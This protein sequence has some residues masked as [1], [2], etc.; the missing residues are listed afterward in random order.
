MAYIKSVD[1]FVGFLSMCAFVMAPS[2]WPEIVCVAIGY[3]VCNKLFPWKKNPDPGTRLIML[4][5]ELERERREKEMVKQENFLLKTIIENLCQ[6]DNPYRKDEQFS[7]CVGEFFPGQKEDEIRNPVIPL[8]EINKEIE[9]I[10]GPRRETERIFISPTRIPLSFNKDKLKIQKLEDQV[11]N[12]RDE[13]GR[14][15]K[16]NEKLVEERNKLELLMNTV[17]QEKDKLQKE[18]SQ[19]QKKER[20]LKDEI[21]VHKGKIDGAECKVQNLESLNRKLDVELSEVQAVNEDYR[22]NL[23]EREDEI[24]RYRSLERKWQAKNISLNARNEELFIKNEIMKSELQH[25]E[26]N[27]QS[28]TAKLSLEGK[29]LLKLQEELGEKCKKIM[30]Q[31]FELRRVIDANE[32][33]KGAL[34]NLMLQNQRL[35][36][37]NQFITKQLEILLVFR[38]N[39]EQI[40]MNV[41]RN[42][43]DC[44]NY[45]QNDEE[46]RRGN[47]RLP[48]ILRSFEQ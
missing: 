25:K 17:N 3:K 28:M 35:S 37:E 29:K 41:D 1:N 34:R 22:K 24:Y 40:V 20:D 39:A 48:S 23:Q 38:N 5:E 12:F 47:Y 32:E 42:L 45:L 44:L 16:N 43:G 4:E 19:L 46:R 15:N 26:Q 33:Y 27:L 30:A 21:R 6:M 11:R 8:D 18:V 2:L 13:L 14:Q 7:D 10:I 36:E 9:E 31:G